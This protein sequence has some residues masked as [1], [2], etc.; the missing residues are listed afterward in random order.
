MKW[1]DI[2]AFKMAQCDDISASRKAVC[3]DSSHGRIRAFR[4]NVASSAYYCYYY[5]Y[6]YF[7]LALQPFMSLSLLNFDDTR[8]HIRAHYSR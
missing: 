1:F 8:S 3:V 5:Y 7:Y 4:G 2:D 6:Y